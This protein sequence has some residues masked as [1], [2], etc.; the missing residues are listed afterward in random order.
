MKMKKY[1]KPRLMALSLS[2]NDMLCAACDIDIYG[3]NA[4]PIW[5]DTYGELIGNGTAFGEA[6]TQCVDADWQIK[7]YCKFT[8]GDNGTRVV[9]NS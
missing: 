1:E 7:G 3:D 9:I 4:N 5:K 2:G 6:E 8:G